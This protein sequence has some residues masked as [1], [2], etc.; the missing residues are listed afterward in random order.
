[1]SLNY[2]IIYLADARELIVPLAPLFVDEWEPYYGRQGPGD[3]EADLNDCCNH[4]EIP[5]AL[6]AVGEDN[7]IFG[8]ASLKAKS[9]ETHRHLTPWLATFFVVERYRG[10]GVGV[11]LVE[12]IE[13]NAIRL[14][15]DQLYVGARGVTS[16]MKKKGWSLLDE[17]ENQ[18]GPIDIYERDLRGLHP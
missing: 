7:E 14:G 9:I 10:Q 5:L 12:E 3:A 11:A 6:V 13:K 8:T 4:N 2:K 16:A 15:Y 18:R 1:M 17:E